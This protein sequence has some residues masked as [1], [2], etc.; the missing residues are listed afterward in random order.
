MIVNNIITERYVG[1]AIKRCCPCILEFDQT[2]ELGEKLAKESIPWL[3]EIVETPIRV[4]PRD[5]PDMANCDSK[6]QYYFVLTVKDSSA[7]SCVKTAYA[8]FWF[9]LNFWW[10]VAYH[11]TAYQWLQYCVKEKILF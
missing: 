8:I 10:K 6:A 3:K 11:T 4:C 5:E 7:D 1:N 2:R 9:S